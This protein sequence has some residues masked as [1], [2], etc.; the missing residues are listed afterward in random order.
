[1]ESSGYPR[2]QILVVEDAPRLQKALQRLFSREGFEVKSALD[3]N[4]AIELFTNDKATAVLL[5]LMLPGISGKD[6]CRKMKS[7]A[8]DIPVLVLSAVTEFADKVLL[9]EPRPDDYVTKPFGLREL[10]VRVE[11]AMSRAERVRPEVTV[12]C[13]E[14]T[15]DF[16]R[17]LISKANRAVILTAHESS[18]GVCSFRCR[19]R[20]YPDSKRPVRTFGTLSPLQM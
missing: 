12:S 4:A 11:S 18:C 7:L 19:T 13:S 6:L 17:M 9:L 10:L 15:V 5:D 3:G 14:I 20:T 16:A 8:S 2:I 1:M